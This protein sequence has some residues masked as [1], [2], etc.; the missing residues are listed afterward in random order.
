VQF[1][2]EITTIRRT[3]LPPQV[4]FVSQ[5]TVIL[6]LMSVSKFHKLEEGNVGFRDKEGMT[7]GG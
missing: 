4:R 5:N 7:V 1:S 6:I 3:S 2:R